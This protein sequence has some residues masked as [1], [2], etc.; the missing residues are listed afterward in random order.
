MAKKTKKQ[1]ITADLR[2]QVI[3]SRQTS[4]TITPLN[5]DKITPTPPQYQNQSL[6]PYPIQEIRKDLTKTVLLCILAISFEV[7]L[8]FILERNLTLPSII[9]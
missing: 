9:K 6:Y 3:F 5:S 7:A 1:K 2:R 4:S 8:Y